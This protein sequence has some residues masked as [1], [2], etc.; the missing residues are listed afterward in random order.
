LLVDLLKHRRGEGAGDN[1]LLFGWRKDGEPPQF[2]AG[3]HTVLK[4]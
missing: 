4:A 3:L 2:R 1:D